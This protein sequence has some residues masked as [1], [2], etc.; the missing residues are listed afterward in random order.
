MKKNI[1]F[2]LLFFACTNTDRKINLSI[3]D[4]SGL[5]EKTEVVL[6]GKLTGVVLYNPVSDTEASEPLHSRYLEVYGLL[7]TDHPNAKE[8]VCQLHHDYPD[9]PLT[10]FHFDRVNS[11]IV[12]SRVVMEDK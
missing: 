9:D 8:A 3:E 2:F 10:S 11:G 7:R 6:K 4:G 5:N 1:L 12:S